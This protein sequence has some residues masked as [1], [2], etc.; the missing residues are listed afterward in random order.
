MEK[1]R[2]LYIGI[3]NRPF[4]AVFAKNALVGIRGGGINKYCD[5]LFNALPSNI[6]SYIITL[7][8]S[9]QEKFEVNDI[10]NIS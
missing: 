9:N 7:K 6:E 10:Y 5:I 2:V 3:K 8:L 4:D 1:T